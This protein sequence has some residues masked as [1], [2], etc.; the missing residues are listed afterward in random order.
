MYLIK[1]KSG[2]PYIAQDHADINLLIQHLVP[3]GEWD[4]LRK[5]VLRVPTKDQDHIF[6]RV[7]TSTKRLFEERA[8]ELGFTS[9]CTYLKYLMAIDR[10][11]K[12]VGSIKDFGPKKNIYYTTLA[13]RP[14]TRDPNRLR[15]DIPNLKTTDLKI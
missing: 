1:T 8:A 2:K 3:A 15:E 4:S 9:A 11:L 10:E 12:L 7:P 14:D 6:V 5:V 13:D